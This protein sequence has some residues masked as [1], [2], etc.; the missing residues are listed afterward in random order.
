V[1]G[2]WHRPLKGREQAF[3]SHVGKNVFKEKKLAVISLA[4]NGDGLGNRWPITSDTT[5]LRDAAADGDHLRRRRRLNGRLN[6]LRPLVAFI[7]TRT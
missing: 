6:R 4:S 7:A 3:G 2:A 5:D 1:D